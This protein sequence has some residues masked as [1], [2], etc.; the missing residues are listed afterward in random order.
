MQL[1]EGWTP[2]SRSALSPRQGA[3]GRG[4]DQENNLPGGA[5]THAGDGTLSASRHEKRKNTVFL[6]KILKIK[7]AL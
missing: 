2:V 3:G 5:V 7:A 4:S 1:T 6:N